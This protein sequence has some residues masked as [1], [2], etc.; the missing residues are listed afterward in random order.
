MLVDLGG[1]RLDPRP[2]PALPGL[3][4]AARPAARR[5]R[6]LRG[7]ASSTTSGTC[8]PRPRWPARSW[9]PRILYFMGVT[10]FQFKVPLAGL[11]QLSPGV[12]AAADRAVGHRHHQRRQPDRRPRRPGRRRGGHRLGRP[13]RLRAPPAAPREPAR[14]TTSARSSPWSPAASAWASCP[15]TSTRP[16]SSWATAARCCSGL[17]M[18]ASTMLIGGRSAGTVGGV[19]ARSGQTYF[20]FAPLFIPFFILGVPIA[21]HGVRL[22]P[23]DGQ[24]HRVL[25][26]GQEPPPPPAAAARATATAAAC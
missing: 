1:R 5:G 12:D 20:F 25:H 26:A 11:V 17:L 8:R 19:A 21:G 18:A 24:P 9:R 6:H 22:R 14:S 16:R 4:G 3:V 7:R 10:W 23:A 15:T 2:R 13:G